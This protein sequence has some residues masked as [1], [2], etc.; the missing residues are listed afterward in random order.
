MDRIEA[1]RVFVTVAELSSFSQAAQV[2][3]LPRSS[4]TAGVQ[5]VEKEFGTRLLQRTTRKVNL[6][7]NGQTCIERCRDLLADLEEL[8]S[9]F[10]ER[11]ELAGK[12]RVDMSIGIAA[13]WIIP[14][15]PVFL[16]KH[17]RLELELGSTDRPVDVI[18]E[19][20]DC[21]IR[22]G[23]V[24][25]SGL[26]ARRLGWLKIL[27]CV[28]PAYIQRYGIPHDPGSL[29]AHRLVRYVPFL[30][31]AAEGFEWVDRT[32]GSLHTTDMAGVLTV[33]NSPAY[34]AACLAGLGMIQVPEIGVHSDL[35]SGSLIEVMPDFRAAPMPV[36]MIF[37][38]R[39][40]LPARVRAFMD[41][42][43]ALLQP[44][45]MTSADA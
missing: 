37:P 31:T 38:H 10:R 40:Q 7:Q 44:A 15:L 4:V 3:N 16:A 26:I 41:W 9:M 21:V 19:G 32:G 1:L 28:S 25:E 29:G 35:A 11:G 45:L 13:N 18:R 23:E 34:R 12:L 36:T 42:A 30:G 2:L 24:A 17:P 14:Q 20:F 33:N 43:E 27:N 22:V 6:T 5:Q 39:R 8:Q